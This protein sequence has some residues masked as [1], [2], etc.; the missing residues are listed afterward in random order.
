M[1]RAVPRSPHRT[2]LSKD[3][4][5]LLMEAARTM[6]S[7]RKIHVLLWAEAVATCVV[8]HSI[9]SLY[10]RFTG[11]ELIMTARRDR[12]L[13]YNTSKSLDLCCYPTNDNVTKTPRPQQLT[14][15]PNST[16]LEITALQQEQRSCIGQRP[17]PLVYPPTKKQESFAPVARLE[18]IRL[19]IA[20]AA[21]MNMVIFQMDVKTAFLNGELN[22][23]VYVSQPEGF[24][25]PG[26]IASVPDSESSA[27][28]GLNMTLLK[29]TEM[30]P[31][32]YQADHSIPQKEHSMVVSCHTEIVTLVPA[33]LSWN[34]LVSWSDP[35]SRKKYGPSPPTDVTDYQ[36]A[37]LITKALRSRGALRNHYSLLGVKQ[38]SPETLKELWMSLSPWS[39]QVFSHSEVEMVFPLE[40]IQLMKVAY[41]RERLEMLINENEGKAE[42]KWRASCCVG[43]S[44]I[45]ASD[46]ELEELMKDQP[47][48]ADASP[49]ALSPGYI[50]DSNPE[51][52]KEDPEEDPAD[53]PADG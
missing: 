10:T 4:N 51:E 6:L 19:F 34:R 14:Y 20:H 35:K 32:C 46:E 33:Q 27:L 52:D 28:W 1:K 12:N 11:K 9:R 48:S 23:V 41:D 21:S 29:A 5:E 31:Y 42:K 2:A 17:E 39:N 25:D 45:K 13:I 15:V 53:H 38:L 37:D 22:E 8:I 18:A 49:T 44:L 40:E 50:A 26:I 36:L 43:T 16:E 47:L 7:L 3:E 24:V 30:L